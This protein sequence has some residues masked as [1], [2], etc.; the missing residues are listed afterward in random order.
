MD[1]IVQ[2]IQ[3]LAGVRATLVFD[4]AGQL[5]CYRSDAG[6]DLSYLSRVSHTLVRVVESVGALH[7]DWNSVTAQF[8]GGQLLLRRLDAADNSRFA[9]LAIVTDTKLNGSLNDSVL[10]VAVGRLRAALEAHV[11]ALRDDQRAQGAGSSAAVRPAEALGAVVA[12]PP[13]EPAG[14]KLNWTGFSP[15]N[16]GA[17]SVAIADEA[18][19]LFLSRCT[20]ALALCVGPMAKVFVKEVVRRL[21]PTQPFSMAES[22]ALLDQIEVHIEDSEERAE[23]RKKVAGESSSHRDV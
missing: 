11:A 9:V 16:M 13:I 2:G 12:Q 23:F 22:A 21:C 1:A 3:E 20:K 6:R 5:L 18:S 4:M 15:T 10:G 7:Q 8:T 14:S 19:G 17:S